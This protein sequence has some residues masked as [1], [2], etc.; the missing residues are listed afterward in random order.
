M[1]CRDELSAAKSADGGRE[2]S[3]RKMY[4]AEVVSSDELVTRIAAFQLP[5]SPSVLLVDPLALP[6]PLSLSV[7]WSCLPFRWRPYN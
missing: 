4:L 7:S 2:E 5:K 3:R 6:R 1:Q